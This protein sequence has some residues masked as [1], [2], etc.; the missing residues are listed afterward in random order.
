MLTSHM[1]SDS[2]LLFKT[3]WSWSQIKQVFEFQQI[4]ALWPQMACVQR[5][6]WLAMMK[7]WLAAEYAG[8]QMSGLFKRL[9]SSLMFASIL[10]VQSKH[11]WSQTMESMCSISFDRGFPEHPCRGAHA[12]NAHKIRWLSCQSASV[13]AWC[14][15]LRHSLRVLFAAYKNWDRSVLWVMS[16]TIQTLPSIATRSRPV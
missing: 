15:K 4:I 1:Q 3:L 10:T 2:T 5:E 16:M 14:C 12:G 11:M 9:W 7:S 13:A 8:S 6:T